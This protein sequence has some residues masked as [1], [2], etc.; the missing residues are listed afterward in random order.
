MQSRRCVTWYGLLMEC[1]II[2]PAWVLCICL[3]NVRGYASKSAHPI[4]TSQSAHSPVIWWLIDWLGRHCWY[5]FPFPLKN[6]LRFVFAF[7]FI[8]RMILMPVDGLELAEFG[9]FFSGKYRFLKCADFDAKTG[10]ADFEAY[11]RTERLKSFWHETRS[12]SWFSEFH[13][14]FWTDFRLWVNDHARSW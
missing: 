6:R 1:L 9:R 14:F 5:V 13:E 2:R 11:P 10:C 4:F 12:A 3:F 7:V 8:R